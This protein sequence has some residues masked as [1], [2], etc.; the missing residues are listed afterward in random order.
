[1]F[2]KEFQ[3]YNVFNT[4]FIFRTASALLLNNACSSAFKPKS[5]IFSQ[6]LRPMTTGTPRQISFW[7]YSPFNDTQQVNNFFS[8]RTMLSTS[9]APV[10]PGAYQALVPMSLV[11]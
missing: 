1:F 3:S 5:R 2:Y 6:P 7:P 4:S 10:A 11:S 9:A 8:S